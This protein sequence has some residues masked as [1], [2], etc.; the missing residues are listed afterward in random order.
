MNNVIYL[1]MNHAKSMTDMKAIL[2]IY[3]RNN[4]GGKFD[5]AISKYEDY[6]DTLMA[7]VLGR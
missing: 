5:E 7:Q 3:R 2:P 1:P 4:V 6:Y